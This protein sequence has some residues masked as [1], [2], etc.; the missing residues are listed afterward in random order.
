MVDPAFTCSACVTAFL[1]ESP[2]GRQ[3]WYWRMSYHERE[4]S[5]LSWPCRVSS[6]LKILTNVRQHATECVIVF[7]FKVGRTFTPVIR[8]IRS[9][10]LCTMNINSPPSFDLPPNVRFRVY[11]LINWEICYLLCGIELPRSECEIYFDN[12]YRP[13]WRLVF[14]ITLEKRRKPCIVFAGIGF[15][16]YVGYLYSHLQA[17]F[18]KFSNEDENRNHE[19]RSVDQHITMQDTKH[20]TLAGNITQRH[21]R[22]SRSGPSERRTQSKTSDP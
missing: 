7:K 3:G 1:L 11:S 9:V 21:T 10:W 4:G 13:V 22:D 14:S 19:L 12:C 20:Y 6:Q 2:A 18:F 17:F 8:Y 16:M 5:G 15:R